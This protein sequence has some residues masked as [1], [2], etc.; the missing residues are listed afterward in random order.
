MKG[1]H[2]VETHQGHLRYTP[3]PGV[4]L[5]DRAWPARTQTRAPRWLST[6]LRDGNQALAVPMS[7]S[8]KLAMFD[9]LVAMGYKEIEV[10]FP[11]ASR[12]D[13]DFVRM[14]IER[15]RIPD[16]VRISVL[17]QARDDQIRR[18]VAALRGA[19][20]VGLHVF[21][22][23]CPVFRT[24][25]FGM[26]RDECRSMAVEGA[27]LTAKYAE[28]DLAGS[29]VVYQYSPELFN[30]TELDFSLEVCEAVLDVWQPEAGRE[31]IL[32][33]PATVERTT[34]NVFADQIE[35]LDRNLSR[36]EHICLSIHPHNDRGTG[37]AATELAVLAGADRVEGCLFGGGERAGNVCLVTLGLNLY[38]QGIDPRIDFSDIDHVRR[39]VEECTGVDV[40]KR[41]PYAGELVFTAFSG[42]HQDAINKGFAASRRD[43]EASGRGVGE[44][45]WTVPYLPIDPGD[46]G[47][48]YDEIVR[49]TSQSGKGGV[50]YVMSTWH[51]MR[52]P[53]ELQIDFARVVQRVADAEGA[54]LSPDRIRRCFDREYLTAHGTSTPFETPAEPIEVTMFLDGVD[55]EQGGRHEEAVRILA[56]T[57]APWG[58]DCREV[59][60]IGPSGAGP[61][62]DSE[63]KAYAS[64]RIG[65]REYWGAG[66]DRDPHTAAFSAVRAAVERGR[67]R[68]PATAALVR[69]LQI[70]VGRDDTAA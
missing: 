23:T 14:L 16:D 8:R 37:V 62:G 47:R 2:S 43:A 57:L 27:R 45:S 28:Q 65:G 39:T 30:E 36:R 12:D 22:A 24:T 53:R 20:N 54:E 1:E 40:H 34:P 21:N 64:C 46:L 48:S 41:H 9:L 51:G 10:G 68:T 60:V 66:L 25:V 55:A 58:M 59:H 13:H 7:P 52:L 3:F 56:A 31:V 35:W 69:R 5:H 70:V 63:I 18:S 4:E 33:F 42:S 29:D 11:V 19:R 61:A 32:N 38:S 44:L 15:D 50:A 6:D 49:I 26:T 67:S 17:V